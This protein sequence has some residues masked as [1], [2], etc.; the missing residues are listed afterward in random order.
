[1][2]ES[3]AD[4]FS[5]VADKLN[6]PQMADRMARDFSSQLL[7]ESDFPA[8]TFDADMR[9]LCANEA[10]Q[11][12]LSFVFAHGKVPENI[13][14]KLGEVF[15]SGQS[16]FPKNSKDIEELPTSPRASSYLPIFI[17]LFA[18]EGN[19]TP[20]AVMILLRDVS[21]MELSERVREN[22]MA[23]VSHELNTPLTSARVALY[24][25]SEQQIGPLNDQQSLLVETA[26]EDLDRQIT[27]IQNLINLT[28]VAQ[29]S[30][31]RHEKE[32]VDL[33]RKVELALMD[34]KTILSSLDI[35]VNTDL[36]EAK[37]LVQINR[38]VILLVL[39]QMLSS[40]IRHV[41]KDETLVVSTS[42]E[43][44]SCILTINTVHDGY[45]EVIPKDLFTRSMTDSSF[46]HVS[47]DAVGLRLAQ[48]I[49][50]DSGASIGQIDQP[51]YKGF[52]LS[53]PATFGE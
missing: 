22:L 36:T 37:P 47:G 45:L 41:D 26:K 25:L 17:P 51:N 4:F 12:R 10:F 1:M 35:K 3:I 49:C 38:E 44:D 33:N 39:N 46:R 43:G 29:N 31:L 20:E 7:D 18:S 34:L 2:T 21:D 27:S 9:I 13:E 50:R 14:K 48:E 53:M 28:R 32:T 6:H 15:E 40:I 19:K 16:L 11:R 24:L 8:V 23:T 5:T 42:R 30:R 52:F